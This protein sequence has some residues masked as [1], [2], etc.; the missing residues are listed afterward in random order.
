M[1]IISRIVLLII[2][3]PAMAAFSQQIESLHSVK[4]GYIDLTY[5]YEHA[6]GKQFSINMEAGVN[7]GLQGNSNH[8]DI[9]YS[10]VLK[11]EPRLYYSVKRRFEIDRFRNNSAS[12]FCVTTSFHSAIFQEYRRVYLS[13][14]P[15]WGFRR[16]MGKHFIFETQI[17]GG[18]KFY[19]GSSQFMPGF[20]IKFGYVF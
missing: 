4:L 17:G 10:P 2:L 16:A 11:I 14:I 1:K 7:C 6:L 3:L 9:I 20:D 5:S 13:V 19:R 15:K 8:V 18:L 12:F